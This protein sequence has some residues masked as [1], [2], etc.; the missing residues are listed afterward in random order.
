MTIRV[1][2]KAKGVIVDVDVPEAAPPR[3]EVKGSFKV[4]NVG[5]AEGRFRGSVD[6][7]ASKEAVLKPGETLTV[8]FTFNMPARD[9][10]LVLKAERYEEGRW[11]VDDEKEVHIMIQVP[12][13]QMI[14]A[15]LGVTALVSGVFYAA[16][17]RWYK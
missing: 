15:V 10:K 14:P 5:G 13:V 12:I 3:S 6:T 8:E 17:K 1:R 11:V 9:V 4:K 16:K 2:A 7:I